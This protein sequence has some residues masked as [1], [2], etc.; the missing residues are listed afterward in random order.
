MAIS[1]YDAL[2][3]GKFLQIAFSEGVRSQ[4]STDFRDWEMIKRARVSDPDGRELQFLLQTA[5]GAAAVQYSSPGVAGNFPK[6]SQTSNRTGSAT[7]KEL[8]S[9]IEIEYSVWDQARRSPAKYA[10]PLANEIQAKTI[11]SKR[12]LAADLYGDGT[13]VVVELPASGT[14]A[15]HVAGVVTLQLSQASSSPGHV[16][17]CEPGD[18]LKAASILGVAVV[19]SS[20][21]T[22]YAYR[23]KGRSRK[24]DQV[25]LEIVDEAGAVLS[26]AGVHNLVAGTLFYRVGQDTIPNRTSNATVGDY[27]R[28]TEVI[29]G[30]L[31]LA[32]NDGR[33][34][35]D[36]VMSGATGGTQLDAAGAA[37]DVNLI[38]ELMDEAKVNVGQSSYSWKM[39]VMAPE[40]N[41]SF[42][43][44]RETDRRFQSIE[45]NKRGVKEFAFVHGNDTLVNYT[46]EFAHK[47]HAIALPEAKSGQKVLE[48]YMT[49]FSPVRMQG[50]SEFHLKTGS[51][52][53]S[54]SVQSFMQAVGTLVCKHPAAIARLHN[55][56]T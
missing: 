29:P 47:K 38:Q 21:P 12:R 17:F 3:L 13:G 46:S 35:H 2:N 43:E 24:L 14:P 33:S 32:A 34:V 36:I 39:L 9:T 27:G 20:A 42:I 30:L 48:S 5:L 15:A 11:V 10:E 51:G 8:N 26:G 6:A 37:I 55:F 49:D 52:G 54:K 53:Y 41:A 19:P 28:A 22:F 16:G 56:I 31:S 50:M 25:T 7:Y 4:I 40:A 1:N 45:D 44:S 18:L 23:I